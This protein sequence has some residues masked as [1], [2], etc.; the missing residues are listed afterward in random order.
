MNE[1]VV[2]VDGSDESRWALR[3]A[4]S[5]A[6]AA[7]GDLSVVQAWSGGDPGRADET[8]EQVNQD[9]A[10]LVEATLGAAGADLD[11]KCEARRGGAV[12]VL[13]ERV[14]L[15]SGLIL[16]SRGRGGFAG[17]LLGSVSRQCIEHA[18]CPVMLI[19][20]EP[21]TPLAGATILVGHDGSAGAHQAL[22]WAVAVAEATGATVVAAYAWQTGASEVR[23]RLHERLTSDA[24]RSVE[25]W[26][27]DVGSE[28]RPLDIEGEPRQEL[29]RLAE[30]LGA[31]LLV[32][33]RRGSGGVRALRIGSVV[34]YLVTTSPV[35][36]A[37]IPPP[38]GDD[39]AS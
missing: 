23:P 30:R 9:L 2:G 17:L 20:Q 31:G 21:V 28:V 27:Q 33:G 25:G 35:P 38:P 4:A 10:T 24:A 39:D 32:V 36:V 29:I 3:W 16:G 1:L 11:V 37:V 5:I 18:P 34:S 6:P 19:R 7:R 8:G 26:T 22:E 14:T 13:L 15:D 12:G